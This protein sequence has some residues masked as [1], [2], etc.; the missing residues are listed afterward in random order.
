M[1][2]KRKSLAPETPLAAVPAKILD[3]FVRQGPLSAEE[4]EGAVRRFKKALIERAL[5]GEGAAIPQGRRNI[6][7]RTNSHFLGSRTGIPGGLTCYKR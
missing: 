2:R 6:G 1:S 3:E 7:T 4:L 5:G